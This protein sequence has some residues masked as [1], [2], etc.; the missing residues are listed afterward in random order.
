MK[1]VRYELEKYRYEDYGRTET[2]I[3]ESNSLEEIEEIAEK[4]KLRSGVTFKEELAI[5]SIDEHGD[6]F[7]VWIVKQTE[8]KK[9]RTK[10]KDLLG[11]IF[12]IPEE[13]N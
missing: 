10:K 3:T 12:Y 1:A 5:V 11:D 4:T 13:V 7:D 6:R 9:P 8:F 2:T